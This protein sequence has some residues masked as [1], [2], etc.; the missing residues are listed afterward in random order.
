M[1]DPRS[2]IYSE[3][4]KSKRFPPGNNHRILPSRHSPC[5][6]SRLSKS[7]HFPGFPAKRLSSG[8]HLCAHLD[9]QTSHIYPHKQ[10]D[11]MHVAMPMSLVMCSTITIDLALSRSLNLH[12]P[13]YRHFAAV[14]REFQPPTERDPYP[15]RQPSLQIGRLPGIPVCVSH[16]NPANFLVNDP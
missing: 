7:S 13:E 10:F 5:R 16:F 3:F 15:K 4:L 14:H 1:N 6:L 2:Q 9:S 11:D 8:H 12:L